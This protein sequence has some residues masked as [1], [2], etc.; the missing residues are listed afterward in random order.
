MN[1]YLQLGHMEQVPEH[2]KCRCDAVYLPHQAVTREDK[3]TT[4]LRDVFDASAKSKN[5]ISLNDCLLVGPSLQPDLRHIMIRWRVHPIC[6]LAVIEKMNRMVKIVNQD[7]DFQRIIWKNKAGVN[8]VFR[9]LT[10]TFGTASA[11]YL[12]I[13]ALQQVAIDEGINYPLAAKVTL[14]DF[15]VDD[16][17]IGSES[18]DQGLTLYREMNAMLGKGGFKLHK[19]SSN[20]NSLMAD[21]KKGNKGEE[22]IDGMHIKL[23]NVFKILGLTWDRRSDSFGDSVNLTALQEPITKRKVLADVARLYDPLGWL[24]PSIIIAK[25]MIQKL[26]LAGLS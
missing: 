25:T 11:P 7:V 23:D 8:K 20:S 12:A 16:V 1:E 21:I 22:M 26:W 4:K 5:G 6:L 10:V 2:E 14:N 3:D 9:L 17:L 24:T 13:K 19:W 18:V 15:Y